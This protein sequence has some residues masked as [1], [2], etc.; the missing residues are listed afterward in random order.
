MK[1]NESLRLLITTC[2][3]M[4]FF[5]VL[6][7]RLYGYTDYTVF[8]RCQ[9]ITINNISVKGKGIVTLQDRSNVINT[10]RSYMQ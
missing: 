2:T 9:L 1:D 3:S 6:K 5:S 8:E 4:L 10:C 7:Q